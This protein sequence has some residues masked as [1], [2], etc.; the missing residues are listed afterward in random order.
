MTTSSWAFFFGGYHHGAVGAEWAGPLHEWLPPSK[1]RKKNVREESRRIPLRRFAAAL[2]RLVSIRPRLR[3]PGFN[4]GFYRRLHFITFERLA[5]PFLDEFM[6]SGTSNPEED[7][8]ESAVI[9]STWRPRG[10][11]AADVIWHL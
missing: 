10:G 5:A 3:P 6:N 11:G 8:L 7:A 1:S 9:S 2:I 4:V